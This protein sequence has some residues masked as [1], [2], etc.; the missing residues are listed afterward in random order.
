MPDLVVSPH[1]DDL[2]DSLNAAQSRA[3]LDVPKTSDVPSINSFNNLQNSV[4]NINGSLINILSLSGY[5]YTLQLSDLGYYIRKYHTNLHTIIIPSNQNI[6]FQ[7]GST[8]VIRN[9]SL[10]SLII[11]GSN[12][13]IL[14]YFDDLSANILDQNTSAQII[15]IG[16]NIWDII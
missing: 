11:S 15:Y 13:V 5:T 7:I 10:N 12:N 8:F 14:N 16:N 1:I 9:T 2:L 4:N 6:P 3:V